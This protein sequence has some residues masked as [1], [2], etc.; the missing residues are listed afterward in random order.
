M[1]IIFKR[2]KASKTFTEK[3]MVTKV[4]R[5]YRYLCII[6]CI[7]SVLCLFAGCKTEQKDET[8]AKQ[9]TEK[10]REGIA[11]DKSSVIIAVGQT[12]KLTATLLSTGDETSNVIWEST[13]AAV[14]TV[15]PSGVITGVSEGTTTVTAS[16]IDNKYTV[17]CQVTVTASLSGISIEGDLKINIGET[18]KIEVKTV[19]ENIAVSLNWQSTVENVVMVSDDGSVTGLMSGT[20]TVIATTADGKYTATCNVTVMNP[21]SSIEF[22]ETNIKINKGISKKLDYNVNPIDATGQSFTWESS[23]NNVAAVS[24]AGV[25]TALATGTVT[26]K[27][28]APNGVSATC[29]VEVTTSVTGIELDKSE[30]TIEIGLTGELTATVLPED[31]SVQTVIWTSSDP[32]IVS[33]G[34]DGILTAL[35]VGS[36]VITASTLDGSMSAECN[37]TVIDPSVSISFEQSEVTLKLGNETEDH[38]TLVP[39]V[40]PANAD[41]TF[42][43]VSS[44]DKIVTVSA[45]GVIRAKELGSAVITVKGSSGAV[46]ELT[47]TVEKAPI[48]ISVE[49]VTVISDEL[50]REGMI[51]VSEGQYVNLGVKISPASATDQTYTFTTSTAAVKIKNGKLFGIK[52]GTAIITVVANNKGGKKISSEQIII[53]VTA[54]DSDS[55]NQAISEY[56]SKLTAENELNGNNTANITAK[57][58][59]KITELENKINSLSVT[60]EDLTA[61]E[62][63]LKVYENNLKK[64]EESGNADEIEKCRGKVT[65]CS[66]RIADIKK[67]LSARSDA[68]SQ[69]KTVKNKYNSELADEKSRHDDAVAKLKEEYDYI[70]RYL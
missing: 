32:K 53:R 70:Q 30:L 47:V 8:T 10:P 45:S 17:S 18:K 26:I 33:V 9:T 36:V 41:E 27:I 29:I 62:A 39:I 46:A 6:L 57:Y 1:I 37:V 44:D 20:S 13:D 67:D 21:V 55:K 64:A 35:K 65:E 15:N 60:E 3:G 49:S 40:T 51:T 52:S 7:A 2:P 28:T 24:E 68:E 5:I 25:V 23:D 63:E 69:L 38:M 50:E 14:A 58:Q 11:V 56:N 34:E 12:E 54:I 16:T 43:W 59:P 22:E 48:F 19:P 61:A 31:A 66:G 42:T 4:K